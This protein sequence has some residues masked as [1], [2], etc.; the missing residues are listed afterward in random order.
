MQFYVNKVFII[1]LF[2]SYFIF[3]LFINFSNI[4]IIL[5]FFI[6]LVSAIFRY[7]HLIMFC[8]IVRFVVL[9]GEFFVYII[10]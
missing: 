9:A 1:I 10:K 4:F 5:L 8:I 7:V 3:I 6:L 2:D